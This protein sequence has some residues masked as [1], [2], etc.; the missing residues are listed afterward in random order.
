MDRR[1]QVFWYLR[2][3]TR[4]F[5]PSSVFVDRV[6][7][8]LITCR[9][10]VEIENLICVCITL[11]RLLV[12]YVSLDSS[13]EIPPKF[14]KVRSC[15]KYKNTRNKMVQSYSLVEQMLLTTAKEQR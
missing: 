1:S 14:F 3:M 4:L 13:S 15:C 2:I 5:Y 9:L 10:L 12:T 11:N 7:A 6:F 8:C